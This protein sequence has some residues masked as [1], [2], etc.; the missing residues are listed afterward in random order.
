M[1]T[2][3]KRQ[4]QANTSGSG[5][6]GKDWACPYLGKEGYRSSDGANRVHEQHHLSDKAENG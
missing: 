5:G 6:Q 2:S 3:T 4:L 1:Q